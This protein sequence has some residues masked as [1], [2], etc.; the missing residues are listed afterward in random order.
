[1]TKTEWNKI[2]SAVEHKDFAVLS[3]GRWI[4]FSI[5]VKGLPLND[6]V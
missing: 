3:D 2:R 1:M 6:S 4:I 5:K